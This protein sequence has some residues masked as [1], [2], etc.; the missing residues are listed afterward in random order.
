MET[1]YLPSCSGNTRLFFGTGTLSFGFLLR[2]INVLLRIVPL[3][4]GDGAR[5]DKK[6]RLSNTALSQ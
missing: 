5:I 6:M 1:L 2:V 4:V 3:G